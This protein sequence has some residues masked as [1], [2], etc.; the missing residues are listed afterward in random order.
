MKNAVISLTLLSVSADTYKYPYDEHA[1]LLSYSYLAHNQKYA[2]LLI[3]CMD[4]AAM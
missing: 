3:S 1:S 2:S 4:L